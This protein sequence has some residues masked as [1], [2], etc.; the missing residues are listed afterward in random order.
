VAE[1]VLQ[2]QRQVEEEGEH[3]ARDPERGELDAG[4]RPA[5]EQP[6]REHRLPHPAFDR[7][8]GGEQDRGADG[9][10]DDH[11]A[12]PAL[13]V[14]A[15]ERQHDQEQTAAEG[16]EPA[17]VDP[18]CVRVTGLTQPQVGDRDRRDPDRDVE[19]EDRLPSDAVDEGAAD[20]GPDRD[21]ASDRRPVDAHRHPPFPA[22]G[23]LL[24]DQ[25]Q[26]DGEHHRA[27]HA[28]ER[29]RQVQ[30]GR[31]GCQ[32][33]EQRCDREDPQAPGEHPPAAQPV[34]QRAGGQHQR[35]QGQRVGVDH[36]LELGEAGP[37]V[38][39]DRRQ[40]RVHDGDV[41][42][43]HEGGDGDGAEGPPP[44]IRVALVASLPL[45]WCH[46]NIS[47]KSVYNLVR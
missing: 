22:G 16:D 8:E 6:E 18:G 35:R 10:R 41:E 27:A 7:K 11:G 19:E 42:E 24:G 1:V 23:E 2:V 25:S 5:L 34:G 38:L 32:P 12:A 13:L 3:R 40:R 21:C 30:E 47:R 39:L 45:C 36:P 20:E 29:S 26:G 4:E 15:Q 31:I 9:E 33:A 37:E 46:L 28:L 14:A 44:A 43:Q 17:P